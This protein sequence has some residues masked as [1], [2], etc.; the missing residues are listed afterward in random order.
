M[1]IV[2]GPKTQACSMSLWY[3]E[4]EISIAKTLTSRI[5]PLQKQAYLSSSYPYQTLGNIYLMKGKYIH[6]KQ[7]MTMLHL[8]TNI[9][10]F[11]FLQTV[12]AGWQE[13]LCCKLFIFL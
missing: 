3:L 7:T 13:H 11:R 6:E 5:Q 12:K 4:L 10:D 8:A 9:M 1:G 2:R